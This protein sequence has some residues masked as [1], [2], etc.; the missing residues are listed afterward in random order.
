MIAEE[1]DFEV[2]WQL[3]R[4]VLEL[5]RLTGKGKTKVRNWTAQRSYSVGGHF[6]AWDANDPKLIGCDTLRSD[7][8]ARRGITKAEM[9]KLYPGWNMYSKGQL[10]RSAFEKGSGSVNSTYIIAIFKQ[11]ENLMLAARKKRMSRENAEQK[12]T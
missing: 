11:F 10:S 3:L 4:D 2:F 5:N 6:H 7:E 9:K 1:K 12:G 8:K